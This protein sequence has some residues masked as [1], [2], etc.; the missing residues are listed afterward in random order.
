MRFPLRFLFRVTF[1]AC[2]LL[3]IFH[4]PLRLVVDHPEEL[5]PYWNEFLDPMRHLAWL[6]GVNVEY[7]G[8]P[9]NILLASVC[10]VAGCVVSFFVHV[11]LAAFVLAVLGFTAPHDNSG[12]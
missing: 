10:F 2:L 11:L 3:A 7:G 9:P 1:G 6:A 4:R 12:R 5:A 8:F